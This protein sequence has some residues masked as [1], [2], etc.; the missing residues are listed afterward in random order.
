M[1]RAGQ[2]PDAERVDARDRHLASAE[3]EQLV[4]PCLMGTRTDAGWDELL[5]F[6]T[7]QMTITRIYAP[8]VWGLAC[9]THSFYNLAFWGGLGMLLVTGLGGGA[10]ETLASL[11]LAIF[12]LGAM[13][14]W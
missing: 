11:L 12:A 8:R 9:A 4:P 14:G 13:D 6:S 10:S 7:R 3:F 5:E 2:P 1:R